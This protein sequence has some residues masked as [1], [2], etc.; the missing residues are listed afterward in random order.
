MPSRRL[1]Y[2]L[3]QRRRVEN[4]DRPGGKEG[5]R[6]M[7]GVSRR[8]ANR[9]SDRTTRLVQAAVDPGRRLEGEDLDTKLPKEAELWQEV[10]AELIQFELKLLET[11]YD[12]LALMSN[13]AS[14]QIR[15]LDLALLE[16]QQQR[17][18]DRLEFWRRR[19]REL[20]PLAVL[21]DP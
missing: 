15:E 5:E 19:G 8:P 13:Q 20:R 2:R 1:G 10:Y 4:P 18:R 7:S 16:A 14:I 17:Y 12:S 6:D 9:L 11:L 21:R 3:R